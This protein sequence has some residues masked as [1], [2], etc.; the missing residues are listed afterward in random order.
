MRFNFLIPLGFLLPSIY[1]LVYISLSVVAKGD[2]TNEYLYITFCVRNNRF[3]FSGYYTC[4]YC[5]SQC[6]SCYAQLNAHAQYSGHKRAYV[7][8]IFTKSKLFVSCVGEQL[9]YVYS[10]MSRIVVDRAAAM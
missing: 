4:I 10:L 9:F 7:W 5:L 6:K 3:L 8:A 2:V 1:I